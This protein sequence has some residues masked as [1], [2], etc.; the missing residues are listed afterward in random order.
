MKNNQKNHRPWPLAST[1]MSRHMH[2][3][4]HIHLLPH[5]HYTCKH[6]PAYT[7]V[8]HVHYKHGNTF[9]HRLYFHNAHYILA[10][11]CLHIVYFHMHTT[12]TLKHEYIPTFI[13]HHTNTCVYIHILIQA[14]KCTREHHHIHI[15]WTMQSSEDT[16]WGSL[17][18]HV[19]FLVVSLL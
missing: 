5:A 1:Y 14:C 8:S 7:I 18:L 16:W 4:L 15:R 2:T 3:C 10:N 19:C 17:F 6:M 13:L 11:I 9:L 12:H